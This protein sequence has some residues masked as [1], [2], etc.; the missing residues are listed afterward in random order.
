LKTAEEKSRVLQRSV[1]SLL[2]LHT[3]I[4]AH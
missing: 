2:T 4:L 1:G 3:W